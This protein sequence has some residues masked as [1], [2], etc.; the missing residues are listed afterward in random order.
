MKVLWIC[1]FSNSEIRHK[2]N[3]SHNIFEALIRRLITGS[4]NIYTDFAKWITNGIKE[5]ENFNDIELH[6]ISPHQGMRKKKE[7]F[8]LNGINYHFYKPDEN[9]FI[10][11]IRK[12]TNRYKNEYKGNRSITNELINQIHPDIIH[13]Y[14]AENP[15]YSITALDIDTIKYPFI[16]SLQTLVSDDEYKNKHKES[17]LHY[18]FHVSIEKKVLKN[19][20]Y[21]GSRVQKYREFVWREINPNVIFLN[22][23][24]AVEE[25]IEIIKKTKIFDFVYFAR[26]IS[27]GADDAIE[28]FAIASKKY[29][30]ITLNIIGGMLQPYTNK[31]KH[32]IKELRLCKKVFFSGKLPLHSD[33][34]NQ[35]QLSKFAILPLKIDITSGTIREAM[36]SGLPVI[37]TITP[38][39][40]ELNKKRQSILLSEQGDHQT[41]AD[42]MIN[43]IENPEL[44]QRLIENGLTTAKERWNN[45]KNMQQLVE[46]YKATINHHK[47]GI[48]IPAELGTKNP[49]INYAQ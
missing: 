5:F 29:P 16:V 24:L 35:I 4:T 10:M 46:A 49:N 19:V 6:V 37:S 47:Y 3:L 26:N 23:I 40:P 21:I 2:L 48:E 9:F 30:D 44:V 12:L 18:S 13:M 20:K 39:T 27:K 36:F 42:N 32:R 15:Y 38:G 31:L 1:H 7:F 41:M 17:N 22:T 43:L 25:K 14:G 34:I 33:V 8:Q 28:A 45:K 11:G